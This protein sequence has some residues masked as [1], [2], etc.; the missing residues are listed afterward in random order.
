MIAIICVSSRNTSKLSCN[1]G[2]SCWAMLMLDCVLMSDHVIL[3]MI[4]LQIWH[5]LYAGLE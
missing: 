4:S 2:D 1:S 5:N 3:T